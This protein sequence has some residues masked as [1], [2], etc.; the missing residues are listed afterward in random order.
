MEQDNDAIRLEYE[1]IDDKFKITARWRGE[2]I[3][4]DTLNPASARRRGQFVN[5]VKEKLPQAD[6]NAIDKELQR[7][8]DTANS[9]PSPTGANDPQEIAA[10]SLAKMPAE[11]RAEAEAMLT[12]PE[13]IRLIVDDVAALGVAGE[14]ELTATVYIIGTSRLLDRPL[15]GILQGPSSSGKSYLIEKVASQFPPEFVIHATQMTPQAL[16][17]MRPGSLSHR[18]I[19]AGERSRIED[20]ERAE[21]SR[22]LREMLSAGRLTKLMP[23]RVDSGIIETV[24]IEQDGPI[25]YV[26]STTMSKVFDEDAN[27]CLMLHTDE[28]PDQTRRIIRQI[29]A[30]HAY[31]NGTEATNRIKLR[32]HALQRMLQPLRVVIPYAERLGELIPSERVEVRRAFAHLL[33]MIQAVA[34]LHQQQRDRDANGALV[35][36]DEDYQIARHLLLKPMARLLGGGLSDPA[37]RFYERL[38]SWTSNEFTTTEARRREKSSKSAVSGWLAELHDA[39]VIELVQPSRGR[40]PASWRLVDMPPRVDEGSLPPLEEVFPESARTHERKPEVVVA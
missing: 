10:N 27:R 14:K 21:A 40:T 18:F 1:R 25:A 12:D 32:H 28:R 33:T 5:A 34:L 9:K 11:I 2:A 20:D 36:T 6:A 19:V 13:L 15:A 39:G 30:A 8:A 26:E 24:Q 31:G 38:R 7:I 35:A 29:A 37:R 4:T 17:H 16:F 22:A 3:F 23:M